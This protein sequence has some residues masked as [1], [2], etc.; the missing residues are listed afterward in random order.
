MAFSVVLFCSILNNTS[1]SSGH[2]HNNR[3]NTNYDTISELEYALIKHNK[4]AYKCYTSVME[5]NNCMSGT[6]ESKHKHIFDSDKEDCL[7]K[8]LC[9]AEKYLLKLDKYQ[10]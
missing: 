4:N 9:K 8:N 1:T 6:W 3:Y 5:C 7:K 2:Y 10:E